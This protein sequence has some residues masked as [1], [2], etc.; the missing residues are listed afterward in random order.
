MATLQNIVSWGLVVDAVAL[1]VAL[2]HRILGVELALRQ[3]RMY[4]AGQYEEPASG[5]HL[6]V[7][8]GGAESSVTFLKERG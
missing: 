2:A 4:G 8:Q 3:D 1:G 7:I 6:Y 5:P